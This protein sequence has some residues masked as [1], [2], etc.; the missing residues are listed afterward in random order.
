[1][2]IFYYA[3]KPMAQLN[4]YA[5]NDVPAT[6]VPDAIYY[7]KRGNNA[8]ET[9]VT[10]TDGNPKKLGTVL[11]TELLDLDSSWI[12]TTWTIVTF[13]DITI[14][15]GMPLIIIANG[16][17]QPIN[18]TEDTVLVVAMTLEAWVGSKRI[19]QIWNVRNDNWSWTPGL[20]LYINTVTWEM[21]QTPT[22]ASWNKIQR[23]WHAISATKI[24]FNPSPDV[25]EYK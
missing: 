19:L 2:V 13:D 22:L 1:M 9:Y 16:S 14:D 20:P 10:D 4:H 8:I 23:L 11:A 15:V 25:V 3:T 18:S 6:W 17:Y 21:T 7:I 12:T 24:Y 5:L